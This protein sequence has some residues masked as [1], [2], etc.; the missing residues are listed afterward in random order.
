VDPPVRDVGGE[1][2]HGTFKGDISWIGK[3]RSANVASW[4]TVLA[5]WGAVAVA[6]QTGASRSNQIKR[7]NPISWKHVNFYGQYD[8]LNAAGNIDLSSIVDRLQ[9]INFIFREELA[10]LQARNANL[11]GTVTMSRPGDEP[12][13]G[14]LGRSAGIYSAPAFSVLG[15]HWLMC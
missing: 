14:A 13:S 9:K 7:I 6:A 12:W 5:I 2:L 8:F 15:I 3:L 4:L 11:G 1:D 10:E